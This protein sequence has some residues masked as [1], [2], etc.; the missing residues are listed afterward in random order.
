MSHES[1]LY[2][3]EFRPTC[4]FIEAPVVLDP[5]I[6]R[7]RGGDGVFDSEEQVSPQSS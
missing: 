4:M 6:V 1:C 2:D 5:T 7:V 3:P